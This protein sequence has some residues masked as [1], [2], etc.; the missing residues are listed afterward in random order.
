MT[1]TFGTGGGETVTFEL[2]D[3]SAQVARGVAYLDAEFP[4]WWKHIDMTKLDLE[5]EEACVLGQAY[6]DN[7]VGI[8]GFSHHSQLMEQRGLSP[9]YYGFNFTEEQI[10]HFNVAANHHERKL[11][12][13][14][15]RAWE[16]LTATWTDVI[17][18]RQAAAQRKAEV[19]V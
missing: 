2:P 10:H 4:G 11:P 14:V 9:S 13:L 17:R 7:E 8:P 18:T 1:V 12:E 15:S 19:S 16:H 5:S 3:F 6:G